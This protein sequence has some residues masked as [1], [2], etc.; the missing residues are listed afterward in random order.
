MGLILSLLVILASAK[1]F[2][3]LFQKL[4]MP[5]VLGE[6]FAGLILGPSFLGWIQPTSFLHF[7][8][9]MAIVFLLLEVGMDIDFKR[10]LGSGKEAFSVASWGV[11]LPFVFSYLL[12][13]F[14]FHFSALTALFIAGTLTATSIG[15]T[16]RVLE[17]LKKRH[18]HEAHIII[19]AA[20]IDDILGVLLL[21][22]LYDFSQHGKIQLLGL[23]L[24]FFK[25]LFFVLFAP[26]VSKAMFAGGRSFLSK[27]H[28]LF[29][30]DLELAQTLSAPF[31]NSRLKSLIQT[32]GQYKGGF[33][34]F[35][36]LCFMILGCL[37]YLAFL[38]GVPLMLAGFAVGLSLSK[39]FTLPKK[40]P[41]IF[42]SFFKPVT[43]LFNQ[44][45]FIG[46]EKVRE[47]ALKQ[48]QDLNPSLLSGFNEMSAFLK[49]LIHFLTPFFFV[50]VGVA[51]DLRHVSWAFSLWALITLL[52][53]TA[54][55]GK[56][57]SGFLIRAPLRQKICIGIAMMPRGEVGLIFANLGWV[58][59]VFNLNVYTALVIV[60]ALTTFFPPLLLKVLYK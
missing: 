41:L 27:M 32:W 28:S 49:P 25:I 60:V 51:L 58:S 5:S 38:A 19:G 16:A 21:A 40:M 13:F 50:M 3:I 52:Y 44:N 4:S 36:P 45:V 7:L 11:L 30:L 54:L 59:G 39:Q 9:E 29:A 26:L 10:L 56:F 1:I 35:L 22:S 33:L 2:G 8:S 6:L 23:T 47:A 57:C 31:Q 24:I 48:H 15:V 20:I 43:S 55:L 14:Y 34:F 18:T 37:S 53:L 17:D 42:L 46:K 12:T